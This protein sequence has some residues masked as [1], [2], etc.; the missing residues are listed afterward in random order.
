M[1]ETKRQR[2]VPYGLVS[3]GFEGVYTGEKSAS[4]IDET[5]LITSRVTDDA[6]NVIVRWPV[7]S[8]TFPGQ[9]KDWDD[10]IQYIN[11]MQARLGP[12]DDDARQIRAH[13][14]SL[15]PCDSGLPVTVDE[16]LNTIGRGK[17]S[18]PSFRNGCWCQGMWWQQRTTQPLHMESMRTVH[19]VLTGYLAGRSR[20]DAVGDSPHAAGFIGRAYD[21]LGPLSRLT[22]VQRLMLERMLLTVEYFTRNS[23]T[24]PSQLLLDQAG[25]EEGEAAGKDLF[26]EGGRGRRLDAEIAE[27][28]GLPKICPR[29]EQESRENLDSIDDPRKKELYQVCGSIASGVHTLSDCHHNTFRFIEGWI[30]G[31]GTGQLTIPTRKAG[32]ERERLGHLLFGYV[33]GLDKWLLGVP[34]QLLLMDLGHLDLGFDPTNEVVRAYAYLGAERTPVKLWLAACLWHNLTYAP[35]DREHLA[36]LVRHKDLLDHAAG[37]GVSVREWMDS[38]VGSDS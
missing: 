25:L 26:A 13:I 23:D 18:E 24:I 27:K 36:G 20:A 10:E 33:L 30:H 35:I 12:L 28:A 17:L 22:G 6:G 19:A 5:E 16:L 14:A 3:P 11:E 4:P 2:P 7:S 8:W 38:A 15:V 9:E 21:W 34:M 29:W 31:I 37:L 1:A 32:T